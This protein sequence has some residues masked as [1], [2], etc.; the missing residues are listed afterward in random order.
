MKQYLAVALLWFM[1]GIALFIG[2]LVENQDVILQPAVIG[3]Y[4]QKS[5]K[6]YERTYYELSNYWVGE[7]G[8]YEGVF[9]QDTI[10]NLC[11]S[12]YPL[13]EEKLRIYY[14]EKYQ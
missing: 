9:R 2:F 1:A 5:L 14:N 11:Q 6:Q 10:R 13:S 4:E 12:C 7:N 3:C 8:C